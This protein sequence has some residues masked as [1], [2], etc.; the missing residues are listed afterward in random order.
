MENPQNRADKLI[1]RI[2]GEAEN[3]ASAELFF[4]SLKKN[5]EDLLCGLK[6]ASF[7]SSTR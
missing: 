3:D 5:R 7:T 4:T 2:L 6:K 1:E